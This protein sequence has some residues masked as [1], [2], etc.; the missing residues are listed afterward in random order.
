MD[1]AEKIANEFGYLKISIYCDQRLDDA[2][3]EL[4][5]AWNKTTGCIHRG[6]NLSLNIKETQSGE[7]E[8]ILSYDSVEKLDDSIFKALPQVEIPDIMM[9]MRDRTDMWSVFTHMKTR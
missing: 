9:H 4:N 6:E 1:N 7:Q 8:W 2:V 5:S 3:N